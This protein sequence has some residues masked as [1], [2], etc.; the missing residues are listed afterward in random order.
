MSK[1]IMLIV[2]NLRLGGQERVAVNT[3]EMLSNRYKV[4]MLT[5]DNSEPAYEWSENLID[6]KIP[7]KP[8]IIL[9]V[10]NV[11]KRAWKVKKIKKMLGID[12]TISFGESANIVNVIS[13]NGD[14]IITSIHGYADLSQKLMDKY[15]YMNSDKVICC[16]EEIKSKYDSLFADYGNAVTLYNPYDINYI[17]KMGEEAVNDVVFTENTIIAHGRLEKVKNYARLIKAVYLARQEIK[18]ISLVIIGEGSER[19]RL[20]DLVKKFGLEGFAE[21]IGFRK[22]PFAYISKSKLYVLSSLNEGF[23]NALV[24]GMCFLPSVSVD[25]KSGPR[26]ILN[27]EVGGEK[28]VG[29]EYGLYGILVQQEGLSDTIIDNIG[30]NDKILADAIIAILNDETGLKSFKEAA[31]LRVKDFSLEKYKLELINILEEI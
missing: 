25:C 16:S 29:V 17:K 30:D 23:P 31:G 24:E 8:N 13:R 27:C 10:I 6:I 12:Y 4:T 7:A 26:E 3:A 9:K 20:E 2:P 22:N 5:F 11:L 14:K 1:N 18:D 19:E 15:I 21:L 28:C